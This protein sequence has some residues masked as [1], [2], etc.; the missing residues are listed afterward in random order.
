MFLRPCS[1]LPI[2]LIIS[3]GQCWDVCCPYLV[4]DHIP[5]KS[6]EALAV[7]GLPPALVPGWAAIRA[8]CEAVAVG[9]PSS[10]LG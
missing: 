9:L 6:V 7:A 10:R 5:D 2:S 1:L 3:D 4:L 8:T